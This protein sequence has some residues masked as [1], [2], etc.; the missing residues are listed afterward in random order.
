MAELGRRCEKTRIGFLL[1]I[2]LLLWISIV[3]V[4][5]RHL[6]IFR[7]LYYN[8]SSLTLIAA[9]SHSSK[10]QASSPFVL[11]IFSHNV[12]SGLID[13]SGAWSMHWCGCGNRQQRQQSGKLKRSCYCDGKREHRSA[14]VTICRLLWTH[15]WREGGI[16]S[17]NELARWRSM[18]CA[19]RVTCFASTTCGHTAFM[20]RGLPPI[21]RA[22]ILRIDNLCTRST[23][24]S[25][26]PNT[27]HRPQ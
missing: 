7:A 15:P 8:C 22:L 19:C 27:S 1:C 12:V 17:A 3:L 21:H 18:H 5:P 13:T 23:R 26:R 25:Q 6:N 10:T 9:H 24:N 11:P 4:L 14:S 16:M 20:T 2:E